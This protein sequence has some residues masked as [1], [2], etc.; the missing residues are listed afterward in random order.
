MRLVIGVV[1]MML[2]GAC[3]TPSDAPIQG[4]KHSL[5]NR[6]KVGMSPTQ[7]EAILGVDSGFERNPQNWDESCY[8]YLYDEAIAPKYVH[9]VFINDALARSTEGHQAIC[10][11]AEVAPAG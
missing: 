3:V 7:V 2:V 10:R 4:S 11:Y 9:A 8:S 1:A 5:A 6:L